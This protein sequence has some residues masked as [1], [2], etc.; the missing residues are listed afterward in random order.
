VCNFSDAGHVQVHISLWKPNSYTVEKVG[1]WHNNDMS[2]WAGV[3]IGK[4]M[5]WPRWSANSDKWICLQV[6]RAC[7]T[8]K[9]L[10]G[11][12]CG[13]GSN[14]VLFNWKDKQAIMTTNNPPGGA[15]TGAGDLWIKPPNGVTDAYQNA[16]GNWVPLSGGPPVDASSSA[17]T[18][19]S[20]ALPAAITIAQNSFTVHISSKANHH[21]EVFGVDGK[22]LAQRAGTGIKQH[23]FGKE[24][25]QGIFVVRIRSGKATMIKKIATR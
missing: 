22:Q 8:D 10:G 12:F 16:D 6:G 21:I 25:G 19:A 2:T 18:L 15:W 11:R 13:C 1:Y 14:Q 7:P 17:P 20:C 4:G 3:D 24:I 23:T 9:G 5:D